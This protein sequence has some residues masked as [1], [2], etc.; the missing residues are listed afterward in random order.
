MC[1]VGAVVNRTRDREKK[2]GESKKI[3][4]KDVYLETRVL[5]ASPL[6]LINML[7]QHALTCVEDARRSLAAKDI[8]GRASAVCKTI[9]VISELRGSLDHSNGGE[10]SKRLE[11]LYEYIQRRLTEGNIKQ[12]DQPFAEVE[13]LLRELSQAWSQLARGPQTETV[14]TESSYLA[15][16]TSSTGPWNAGMFAATEQRSA[17]Y[18]SA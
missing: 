6:D 12:Q 17:S 2:Q 5:T 4:L 16:E 9:A 10:I 7:Y 8:P 13:S 15:D 18:W 1:F 3:M 11:S 14:E